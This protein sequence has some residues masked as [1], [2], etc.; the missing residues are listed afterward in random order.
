[1]SAAQALLFFICCGL[2]SS[3]PSA[4]TE[5]NPCIL[6]NG[7]VVGV[8]ACNWRTDGESYFECSSEGKKGKE[9]WCMGGYKFSNEKQLCVETT[10]EHATEYSCDTY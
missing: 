6:P 3:P 10:D 4:A 2:L 9:Q 8:G 5:E 1:M 7:D